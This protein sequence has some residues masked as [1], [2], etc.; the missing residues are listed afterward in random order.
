MLLCL[1]HLR[2][3]ALWGVS[4]LCARVM[5]VWFQLLHV[6]LEKVRAG[7]GGEQQ[8]L[9]WSI[10]ERLAEVARVGSHPMQPLG[11]QQ[12]PIPKHRKTQNLSPSLSLTFSRNRARK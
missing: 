8:A 6:T 10:A 7:D 5:P 1:I 3:G 11:T 12:R 2:W 4:H 9:L